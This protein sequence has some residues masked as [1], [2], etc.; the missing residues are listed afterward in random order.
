MH[1]KLSVFCSKIIEAGWLAAV[2]AV[3]LFF[4]IY[5]ARTFEPD[6]ITLLRSIAGIM[7]LAWIIMMVEQGVGNSGGASVP[8]SE[9][10]RNWLKRPLVLPT[11]LLVG[12][13]IISTIFS[14]SPKVSLWGSY[15]RLQ[16]TYS[17]L[18]YIVVFALMAGTMRTRA[19]ADRLI[20]IIIITSV[21]VGLY[22]II[23]RYG[24]QFIFKQHVNHMGTDV[25]G[26]AYDQYRTILHF[27]P[28][29]RLQ[30]EAFH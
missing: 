26:A 1:T 9:R 4:N 3:P 23:Q 18:S 24:L 28:L 27:N 8:W 12:L 21:P 7:I 5:T 6:K 2:V 30:I 13:Y 16:G 14:I 15:Q 20:T 17:A 19:Q 25:S 11:L 29:L 22:G 10:I